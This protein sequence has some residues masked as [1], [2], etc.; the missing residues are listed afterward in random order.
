M[1]KIILL[2]L[3]ATLTIA[4]NE[5]NKKEQRYIQDSSGVLNNLSVVI[6]NDLWNLY[7]M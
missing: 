4:C 6:D 3:A 1:K 7:L 5:K 2:V